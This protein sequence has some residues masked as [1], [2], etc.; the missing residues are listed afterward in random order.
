[1]LKETHL[2][3]EE[4][5]LDIGW[6]MGSTHLEPVSLTVPPFLEVTQWN[7]SCVSPVNAVVIVLALNSNCRV[8]L[9]AS[10]KRTIPKMWR[11]IPVRTLAEENNGCGK[12]D[13]DDSEQCLR[14]D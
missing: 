8:V 4:K 3:M 13:T 12:S 9:L 6:K 2:K 10:A 1:M 7:T 5:L 11:I 14:C